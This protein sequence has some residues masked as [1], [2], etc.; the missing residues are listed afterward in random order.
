MEQGHEAAPARAGAGPAH[1]GL[2]VATAAVVAVALYLVLVWVPNE[3]TM[4]V[5]SRI[6]YFHVASAWNAF[7]AFFVVMVASVAYLWK[8]K[9]RWDLVAGASAEV[10]VLFTT[11][12]LVTGTLWMRPVWN[13]WWT[14]DPRLTTT[15]VL[16]F[17]YVGYLVLRG[18]VE[19]DDRRARLSAVFGIIAFVDV[20]VVFES[21]RWWRTIHPQVLGPGQINIAPEMLVTLLVSVAAFTLLYA[22]LCWTAYRVGAAQLSL[23]RMKAR[24][25]LG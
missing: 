18:T 3:R 11:I 1:L 22:S 17:L 8:R 15:T 19:G 21:I 10:G 24:L 9:T 6:F 23:E 2:T 25:R 13:V 12:A 20:P 4:G 5:V 7:L 16:W 14:W